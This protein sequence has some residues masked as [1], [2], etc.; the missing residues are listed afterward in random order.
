VKRHT[1]TVLHFGR[2][3][4][5]WIQ[6]DDPQYPHGVYI[7]VSDTVDRRAI[8]RVGERV[9]FYLIETPKGPRAVQAVV[10]DSHTPDFVAT[11]DFFDGNRPSQ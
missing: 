3:G 5:G 9:A 6:D 11:M 8:L 1:G 2:K 4:F 7:H 10:L